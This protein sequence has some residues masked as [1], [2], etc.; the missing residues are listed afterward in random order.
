MAKSNLSLLQSVMAKYNTK[1]NILPILSAEDNVALVPLKRDQPIDD[2][3]VNVPV[4]GHQAPSIMD[5]TCT[6]ATI[7]TDNSKKICLDCGTILDVHFLLDQYNFVS[8]IRPKKI[9]CS[10]YDEIPHYISQDLKILT[11]DIYKLV[12]AKRIFRN[13]FRKSIILACLHRSSIIK[14]APIYFEDML[15]MFN[16]KTHDANKGISFVAT[17]LEKNSI[18]DI[19]FS[20][21]EICV[22]STLA[23]VDLVRYRVQ[24]M[25]IFDTVKS[26]SD[27]LNNSHC[28]S[29]VC[30]CIYFY[31]MHNSVKISLKQF[32]KK[33]NLAESTIIK[34]FII[35]KTIIMKPIMKRLFSYFLRNVDLN[36]RIV[37]DCKSDV[38]LDL[39][40][41]V[42]SVAVHNYADPDNISVTSLIDQFVYPLDDVEDIR[43]WNILFAK[44]YIDSNGFEFKLDIRVI[45]TTKNLLFDFKNYISSNNIDPADVIFKEVNKSLGIM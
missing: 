36:V 17:N 8:K 7:E 44:C 13:I 12:T 39:I 1:R 31:L 32:S 45:E 3:T 16:L 18:Y 33:V 2:K 34:K 20:N 15:E 19:P 4:G 26:Q 27:L 14:K 40:D 23:L 22:D 28:K 43:D 35:I 9:E 6:H 37:D 29:V 21:D 11:I 42:Q 5:S 25:K 38:D 24:V 10:I 30:G 41:P